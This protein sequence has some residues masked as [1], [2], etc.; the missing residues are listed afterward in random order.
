MAKKEKKKSL[1]MTGYILKP[2]Y[3]TLKQGIKS[4][5][6]KQPDLFWD[7]KTGPNTL[8]YPFEKLDLPQ[9]YRGR[10]GV[11]WEHCVSCEQCVRICPN[12]CLE[13]GEVLDDQGNKKMVPAYLNLGRCLYCGFCAEICP[14]EAML[15]TEAYE[16]SSSDPLDMIYLREELR[17][18][19]E[20][21]MPR[22]R[23]TE[24]SINPTLVDERKFPVLDVDPCINCSKCA[25][26]CPVECIS[27]VQFAEKKRGKPKKYPII[28]HEICVSCRTCVDVCPV[29]CLDMEDET[30]VDEYISAQ[31]PLLDS[32]R[33]EWLKSLTEEGIVA[34]EV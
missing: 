20:E 30:K 15:M 18:S 10:P 26:Y 28:D 16:D 31:K 17:V 25:K 12:K 7:D 8:L 13:M 3:H 24:D 32:I 2:M 21:G 11:I 22:I 27:M 1:S 19:V 33:D 4:T 9:I 5:F 34:P 23:A 14:T 6:G 29:E